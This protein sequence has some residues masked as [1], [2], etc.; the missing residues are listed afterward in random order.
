MLLRKEVAYA[1]ATDVQCQCI[2]DRVQIGS[3]D[4][5]R[6]RFCKVN[7]GQRPA[8][9]CRGEILF[10]NRTICPLAVLH[11]AHL[12][13]LATGARPPQR[14]PGTVAVSLQ[15][16]ELAVLSSRDISEPSKGLRYVHVGII[17]A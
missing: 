14:N 3:L 4:S 12:I 8:V 11:L 16:S 5:P 2:A 9:Y 17:I 7:S 6:F 10:P 13:A 1:A 15:S